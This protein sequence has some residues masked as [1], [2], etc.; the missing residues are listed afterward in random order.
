MHTA[1]PYLAL[2]A[3]LGSS[4]G[5][6]QLVTPNFLDVSSLGLFSISPT[7]LLLAPEHT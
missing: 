6:F 2:H 3:R 4:S 7:C 5:S 1:D